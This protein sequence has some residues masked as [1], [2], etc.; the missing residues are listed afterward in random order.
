MITV[1]SPMACYD[2]VYFM[3]DIELNLQDFSE[4]HVCAFMQL[5]SGFAFSSM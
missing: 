4:L 5:H 2:I 1:M 3:D